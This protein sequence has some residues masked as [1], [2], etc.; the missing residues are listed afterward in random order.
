MPP[1]SKAQE[2]REHADECGRKA[3]Q[4]SSEIEKNHWLVLEK[5]WLRMADDAAIWS[6]GK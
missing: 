6:P 3:E 4:C 2:Y 5:E 1:L